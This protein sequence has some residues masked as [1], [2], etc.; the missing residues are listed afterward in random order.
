MSTEEAKMEGTANGPTPASAAPE[1]AHAS[2]NPTGG[3]ADTTPK[4]P[5]VNLGDE[6]RQFG[7]QIESLFDSARNSP[8]GKEIQQQLTTAWRDVERGINE[9]INSPQA[10]D[11]KGTVSGTAQYA[12]DE[13][14]N[15]M[16]RGLHSLNTWMSQRMQESDARRKKQDASGA[17]GTAAKPEDEI[18]NRFG[19]EEP[20]FGHGVTVPEMPTPGKDNPIDDRFG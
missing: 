10:A 13:I 7:K 20:V 1:G 19:N 16:A 5:D 12:A 4:P 3:T 8:R 9:K 14:Q 11:I 2:T 18:K 17:P 15:G 6:L